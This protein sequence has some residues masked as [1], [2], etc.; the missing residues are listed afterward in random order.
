MTHSPIFAVFMTLGGL[1]YLIIAL[2]LLTFSPHVS[3]GQ[4]TSE[5]C[6]ENPEKFRQPNRPS[7]NVLSI[8]K[9]VLPK[10]ASMTCHDFI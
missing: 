8:V 5:E 10:N 1:A 6:G 7:G 4:S 3:Y 9:E 2:V